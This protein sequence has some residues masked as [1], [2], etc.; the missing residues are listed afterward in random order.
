[1][2]VMSCRHFSN[3][4]QPKIVRA[5]VYLAMLRHRTVEYVFQLLGGKEH[6]VRSG[7]GSLFGQLSWADEVDKAGDMGSGRSNTK[8]ELM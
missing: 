6:I 3:E 2:K 4:N 1:M 7:A 8:A 5:L